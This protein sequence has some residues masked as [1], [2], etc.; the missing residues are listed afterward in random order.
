V[1]TL[2]GRRILVVGASKG[3]GRGIAAGLD[4]EG[5]S[6]A[7]AG[8]SVELLESLAAECGG[9]PVAVPCDVRDPKQC[10]E[11]VARTVEALRG[12]DALVFTPGTTAVTRLA[13]AE[14]EHWRTVFELNV[15][16]A[17][18]VTA[19]AIPHLEASQGTAIFLSSVSAHVTP[20]WIGMG[21]YAASKVA[22]E[23]TVEVWKLEHP[24][25]RFTTI[26]IGSTAGGQFFAD[27]TI[28]D[29]SALERFQSEWSRRG[30]LADEQLQPGDQ[31]K[32]VVD[33]LTSDAQMDVVWSRPR[34]L[35]Q[36]PT[37]PET[38]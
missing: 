5:A 35:L 16:A 18:Q 20:P 26:I 7:I 24:D 14:P 34:R 27:A 30:Y 29:R 6:V 23:K 22:L 11:M 37:P 19:A 10:E 13:D 33:V 9:R 36:L 3:I 25:V 17:G 32:A 31:A 21:L 2:A 1:G 12:L 4:R 38:S 28:P 15:F 8:R